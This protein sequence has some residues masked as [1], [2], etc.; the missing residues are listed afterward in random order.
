MA[1][2]IKL[3]IADVKQEICD[4]LEYI[5]HIEMEKYG[6]HEDY[7]VVNKSFT[8]HAYEHS[9]HCINEGFDPDVCIFDLT[10]NGYSGIDLYKYI[11]GKNYGKKIYLC[12]YTG[13]EKKYDKRR[14]AELM[15]SQT[16]G[17][18]SVIAKPNIL[19]ILEWF[20]DI[21]EQKYHVTKMVEDR[22]PFDLL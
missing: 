11:C 4:S 19:E 22:D 14:E 6:I 13:I 1:D 18:I 9:C 20:D 7:L 8:D 5:L 3:L 12:I 17:L 10:F 21:I 15:A 16:Q 2:K